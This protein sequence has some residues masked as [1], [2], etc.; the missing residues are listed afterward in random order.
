MTNAEVASRHGPTGVSQSAYPCRYAF[1]VQ[2]PRENRST[3]R[4]PA[5]TICGFSTVS[6]GLDRFSWASTT[7]GSPARWSPSL[8]SATA[9]TRAGTGPWFTSSK[10]LKYSQAWPVASTNG[11]GS[12]APPSVS[13]HS[14]GAFDRSA[15]GPRGLVAVAI[16]KQ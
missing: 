5:R 2:L 9:K 14:T 6:N 1:D 7:R 11:A 13:S 3:Y 4:P 15:N 12:I 8:V 16:D 10:V